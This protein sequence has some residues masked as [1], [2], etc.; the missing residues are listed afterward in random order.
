[1]A[2][3]KE[4]ANSWRMESRCSRSTEMELRMGFGNLGAQNWRSGARRLE[5]GFVGQA[6]P[7]FG[8]GRGKEPKNYSHAQGSGGWRVAGRGGRGA[9]REGEASLLA[10]SWA[11]RKRGRRLAAAVTG[12]S[13]MWQRGRRCQREGAEAPPPPPP[14]SRVTETSPPSCPPIQQ[15]TWYVPRLK[16]LPPSSCKHLTRRLLVLLRHSLPAEAAA[17]C[18][19]WELEARYPQ[20]G[21][22]SA[23]WPGQ[24]WTQGGRNKGVPCISLTTTRT[25]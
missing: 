2:G 3:G 22:V 5:R 12:G 24:C 17:R 16:I 6:G 20:L 15:P 11:L 23:L 14:P 4:R 8:K 9:G 18:P 7:D 21:V 1:M 13:P 25:P 10:G 19:I